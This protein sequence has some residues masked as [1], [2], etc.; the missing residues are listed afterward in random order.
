ML[1]GTLIAIQRSM[2]CLLENYYDSEK[3]VIV[4]PEVLRQF[5]GCDQ[6]TVNWF[7]FIISNIWNIEII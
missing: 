1:N 7:V 4:I 3:K 6:L 2:T 5:I